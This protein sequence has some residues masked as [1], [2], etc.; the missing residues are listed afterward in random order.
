MR[1]IITF[2]GV[3]ALL[4]SCKQ[5][6]IDKPEQLIERDVMVDIMYDLSILEAMKYQNPTT[7]DTFK[8]N[9]RE[10]IFKKYKIDSVTYRQNQM[11]YAGD[12]RKFKK[13]YKKVLERLDKEKQTESNNKN[14]SSSSIAPDSTLE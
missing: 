11:Y 8:I 6:V 7:L 14:Q 3:I 4:V 2:L 13:I 5:E 10:Y 1:K 9:P 12:A